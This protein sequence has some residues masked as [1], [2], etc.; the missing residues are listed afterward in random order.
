MATSIVKHEYNGVAIRQR[1]SDDYVCLTDMT[2]A[3]GRRV[4][5]FLDLPRTQEFI[6]A[7]AVDLEQLPE[8]LV[9]KKEGRNGGTYGHPVIAMKLAQWVSISFELW[10]NKTLVRVVKEEA[11]PK[12]ELPPA[13]VRVTN[14]I[15]ALDRLG[16][17]LE[18]PRFNQELQDFTLD[19]LLGKSRQSNE[20]QEEW[21][22]VAEVA[23]EMGYAIALVTKHRIGLGKYVA[24]FD[25]NRKSEKRLCNGTQR[26]INLY[27]VC[28]ELKE[29]ISEYMDAKVLCEAAEV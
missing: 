11:S 10:A 20:P 1:V 19:L 17:D 5:D 15:G 6:N 14:L 28:A 25:L 7:L 23:E 29:V 4:G 24:A 9:V 16:V 26:S 22:G 27:L 12:I 2:K 13:D 21:A 8:N 18:N 3:E